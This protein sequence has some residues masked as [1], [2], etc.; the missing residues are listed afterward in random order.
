MNKRSDFVKSLN[1]LDGVISYNDF[2]ID[3][4]K[5]FDDQWYM[6]KEDILQIK[7]GE[8]FILDVGW[9]PENDPKGQF[10]VVAIIDQ[11]WMNPLSK[12]RCQ[13]LPDL[14]KAIE[15]T[16]MFIDNMRK[17]DLPARNIEYEEFD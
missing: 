9:Y 13:S 17:K 15:E 11:D 7:F 12:K 16:A 2:D 6:F 8:R 3:E 1:I 14:K 10:S 5:S 4:K